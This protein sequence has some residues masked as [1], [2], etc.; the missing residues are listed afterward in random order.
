MILDDIFAATTNTSEG[1]IR[2]GVASIAKTRIKD[3]VDENDYWS[4]WNSVLVSSRSNVMD[5][6]NEHIANNTLRKFKYFFRDA[7]ITDSQLE[8]A[9][10]AL[11]TTT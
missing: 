5:N 4:V 7:S 2:H 8:A 1:T 10:A 3:N 6:V 9:Y 11:K